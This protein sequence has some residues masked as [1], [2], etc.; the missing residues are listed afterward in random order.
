MRNYEAAYFL[1][2]NLDEAAL[3][4]LNEKFS[5]QLAQLGGESIKV[6]AQGKKRLAYP[7]KGQ[8]EGHFVLL[9]FQGKPETAKELS[10]VFRI[11]DEVLRS[12]I[13][14]LN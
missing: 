8:Q 9:E 5:S 4:T 13:V 6:N 2:P 1:V 14:K 11:A 3:Q 12:I 7:V 10:R